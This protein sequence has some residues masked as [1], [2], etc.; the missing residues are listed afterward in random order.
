MYRKYITFCIV[1]FAFTLGVSPIFAHDEGE[2]HEHSPSPS[3]QSVRASKSPKPTEQ[4]EKNTRLVKEEMKSLEQK[5]KELRESQKNELKSLRPSGLKTAMASARAEVRAKLC[6]R[7]S[8]NIAEI[9]KRYESN[10]KGNVARYKNLKDKTTKLVA[11]LKTEGL[12]TTALENA[13]KELEVKIKN[14]ESE[15][16]KYVKELQDLKVLGCSATEDQIK[17]AREEAKTQLAKVRSAVEAVREY[18]RTTIRTEIINLKDQRPSGS[19]RVSAKATTRPT[20][21]PTVQ[22]SASTQ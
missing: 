6:E 1:M 11:R 3:T 2:D 12:N 20:S 18:Y 21:Q 10:H 13:L 16:A 4:G 17:A 19:P 7:V 15:H 9:S 22:P 14:V 5:A 8:E